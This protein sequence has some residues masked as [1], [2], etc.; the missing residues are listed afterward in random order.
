MAQWTETS[1]A[2]GPERDGEARAR[3]RQAFWFHPH[4]SFAYK[5]KYKIPKYIHSFASLFY[6]S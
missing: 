6:T 1:P 4:A 2:A 5:M 3:E